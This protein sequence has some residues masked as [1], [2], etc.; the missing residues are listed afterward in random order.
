MME[1]VGR[2]VGAGGQGFW[3]AWTGACVKDLGPP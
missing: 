2:G 3:A 1:S